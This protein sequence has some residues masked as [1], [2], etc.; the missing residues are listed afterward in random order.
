M[1][2]QAS[3][4]T[5]TSRVT[6]RT[7][8][9]D[10]C[11]LITPIMNSDNAVGI[12][13]LTMLCIA[14]DCRKRAARATTPFFRSGLISIQHSTGTS[15]SGPFPLEAIQQPCFKGYAALPPAIAA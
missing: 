15:A 6:S 14:R 4:T 1:F 3:P 11:K 5:S 8:L 10:C 9:T 2:R 12:W 7:R 13:A